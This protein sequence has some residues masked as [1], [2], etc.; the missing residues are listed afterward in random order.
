MEPIALGWIGRDETRTV[1]KECSSALATRNAGLF[2]P[3]G[4]ESGGDEPQGARSWPGP[5][6]E[7]IWPAGL[8]PHKPVVVDEVLIPWS[9]SPACHG[10]LYG[11]A[12]EEHQGYGAKPGRVDTLDGLG[13]RG[14]I[15]VKC[16]LMGNMDVRARLAFLPGGWQRWIERGGFMF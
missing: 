10:I 2:L 14:S 1:Q 6:L 7:P 3:W 11:R 8:M 16:S 12:W 13:S 4:R 15:A 9:L 5:A